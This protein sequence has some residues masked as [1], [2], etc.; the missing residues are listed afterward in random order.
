VEAEGKR[1]DAEEAMELDDVDLSQIDT[2]A[3][4]K[5]VKCLRCEQDVIENQLASHMSSHSSEI[6]PWLFLGGNRNVEN[7]EEL[8]VR[9]GITHILNLAHECNLWVKEVEIPVREYND[10]LGLDFYYKKYPFGDTPEQ[11]VLPDLPDAINFIHEAHQSDRRHK[12]L[13]H[14]VQ[15]IS[16]SATV[17]IAYLMKYEKMNLLDAHNHTLKCR[18]IAS[19]RKEFVDQLGRFECQIHGVSVPTLTGE[20]A[21]AGKHMLNLDL[22]LSPEAVAAAKA[23][24]WAECRH[25][26]QA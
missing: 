21:F 11:D 12:V 5:R 10:K 1:K 7:V 24:D 18:Q 17:V 25:S 14:C 2:S 6:L 3:R 16:R 9:T 20:Q 22:S 15:G 19:P 26:K 23:A 13:V 8:T 4:A